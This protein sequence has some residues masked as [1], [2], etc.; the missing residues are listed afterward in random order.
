M[1]YRF[2]VR[3]PKCG[4]LFRKNFY[5]SYMDKKAKCPVCG[6]EFVVISSSRNINRIEGIVGEIGKGLRG[7]KRVR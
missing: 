3:C 1:I 4:Q 7:M 5:N 6:T 2:W